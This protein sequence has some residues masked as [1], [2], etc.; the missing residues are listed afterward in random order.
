M[1]TVPAICFFDLGGVAAEFVPER[2]LPELARLL[3]AEPARVTESI[4]SSGLSGELDAGRFT[5]DEMAAHLGSRFHCTVSP[6]DLA[7]VWCR[8]FEPSPGVLEL[9]RAVGER[10]AVGLLTN[11]PP[12]LEE[13]LPIHLPRLARAFAP[14]LFSCALRARKPEPELYAAVE[15]IT[16]RAGS[17][18]ALIDDS[19]RNVEA[20]RARGWQALHFAEAA[21]LREQ[22]VALGWISSPCPPFT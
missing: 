4:W 16:G 18:L 22:L 11:N 5:L 9:A 12:A 19:D 21:G 20:A 8:A 15:R 14:L 3:S 2:Q 10:T 7:R 6:P 17:E 13:G 1:P